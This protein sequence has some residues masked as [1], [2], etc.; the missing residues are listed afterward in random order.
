MS[1]DRTPLKVGLKLGYRCP[2]INQNF[3][4]PQSFVV[5]KSPFHQL[6]GPDSFFEL[7][8]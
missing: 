3:M 6:L 4:Y 5:A 7:L 8:V 2:W 1:F